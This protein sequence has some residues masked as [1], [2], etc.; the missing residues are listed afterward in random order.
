MMSMKSLDQSRQLAARALKNVLHGTVVL[1]DDELYATARQ[2][3]NCAV[4]HHPAMIAFCATAEDVQ[5]A[6]HTAR[7]YNLPISVRGGGYD[8]EGRS[9]RSDGLVIDLSHMNHVEVNGRIATV[10]GGATAAAVISA[11]A[12]SGLIAVTGWNGFIGMA[13]LTLAG[14]YG[15]LIASHGL[16]LDSLVGAELVLADGRRVTTDADNNPDLLWA[17]QG[18]G[19][20]FGVVT[21][22]KFRLHPHRRVVGGMIL[23]PWS[24]ADRV[25]SG[26]ADKAASAGNDL[27][28][29]AGIFCLP[30]G[31]PALFLA[32]AWTGEP[33]RGEAIMADL[34][35]LGT[36]VHTQIGT[37]SYQELIKSFDSRVVNGRHYAVQTRWVPAL[38]SEVIS[39]IIKSA[40]SLSS[41]F[42]TI[43]LQHFRG[44]AAQIPL[45]ATAFGL[46]H[47]HFLVEIIAA[48]ESGDGTAN[49]RSWARDHSNA[50]APV[51]LPGGYPSILGPD[52]RAQIALAYGSNLAKLR[53]A[54]Q[55]FDPDGVFSA[56]PLPV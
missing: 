14:G 32:P 50:L 18:G 36:P 7:E 22:M 23:F 39:A 25:L 21:S 19:G 54:K 30:D 1:P 12:A 20:N 24:D 28:V 55:R 15:P 37:M 51:S 3:W 9:V 10:A 47:E 33:A 4:D 42:S 16:A 56:T 45:E 11:A 48:W 2:V 35:A 40:S 44:A 17:L 6:V 26:Y 43:I 27:T 41:P 8:V 52:D 38:T 53:I 29:L 46:R 34:Q 49:H 5:A 13:G 31:N